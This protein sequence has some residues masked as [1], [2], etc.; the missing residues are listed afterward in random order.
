MSVNRDA[1][2]QAFEQLR[3][4]LPATSLRGRPQALAAFLEQGF[5]TREIED[6]KYTDLSDLS[7]RHFALALSAGAM[8][9]P[10]A[11]GGAVLRHYVNGREL[12]HAQ[13]PLAFAGAL[14][15]P[16]IDA[17]NAAF[18]VDGLQLD[19]EAGDAG[20]SRLQVFTDVAGGGMAHLRHHIRLAANARASIFFEHTGEGEYLTTQVFDV[21]L[22]ANSQL[23]FYRLQTESSQATHLSRFDAKVGPDAQLRFYQV[24]VGAALARHDVNLQLMAAGA[25]V[26]LR[27]VYASFERRHH[28]THTRIE[29]VAPHGTSREYFRGVVGDRARAVFNGLI[30]VAPGAHKTDSEQQVANLLLSRRAEVNAKPELQIFNDDVRCIHGATTG[31]LEQ[32]AEFYLRSRGLDAI[33]ARTLLTLAFAREPLLSIEWGPLRERL[34]AVVEERLRDSFLRG[35]V[36]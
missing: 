7:Q 13:P 22:G 16:A 6:W 18:A 26:E 10:Q 35:D 31:A 19:I 24:D 32:A 3:G 17:L 11:L 2:A 12:A 30:R 21:E 5:P 15:D 14:R 36:A 23:D 8:R 9:R 20:R 34:E 29:H 1:Y 33:S 28:D 4:E 27:G 25:Q